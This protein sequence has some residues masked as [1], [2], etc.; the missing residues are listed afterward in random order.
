MPIFCESQA[1]K[2]LIDAYG[3]AACRFG[4]YGVDT[5]INAGMDLE[6]PGP[7]RWR[8]PLL[9]LQCLSAQKLLMPTLDERVNNMLRFIQRQ[10]SRNPE[11]VYGD[12]VER[13]RDS[14]EL[15]T[16]ARTLAAEG[17]VLLK[18]EGG[19]LPLGRPKEGS[20]GNEKKKRILVTGAN[21]EANV[22]SGGGSA[23]L[24]ATYIATPLKSIREVAPE[25]CEVV[26]T[27][28]CYCELKLAV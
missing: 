8:T 3:L 11:V 14:P 16:F 24:K 4:T 2:T 6:M 26:H 1:I 5:A 17:I 12:G 19:V 28:G 23:Q 25:G 15:R 20:D 9:V 18:N 13:S 10:A 21:V 7:P 27:V 22:I